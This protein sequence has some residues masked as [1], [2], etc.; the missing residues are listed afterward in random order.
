MEHLRSLFKNI[1]Q[2]SISPG[3]ASPTPVTLQE[4]PALLEEVNDDSAI[5]LKALQNSLREHGLVSKKVTQLS[6]HLNVCSSFFL[7]LSFTNSD[8][9]L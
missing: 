5:Y 1:G 9:A 2:I 4:Q 3:S 7:Y 8:G 6:D